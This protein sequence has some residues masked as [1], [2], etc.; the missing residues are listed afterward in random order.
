MHARAYPFRT[1]CVGRR[2][3]KSWYLSV[4]M[5]RG[6]SECIHTCI[7]IYICIHIYM[8]VCATVT[9][10][11]ATVTVACAMVVVLVCVYIYIYMYMFHIGFDWYMFHI[12]FHRLVCM[13]V[14]V[15]SGHRCTCNG[16]CCMCNGGRP[17]VYMYASYRFTY[18]LYRYSTGLI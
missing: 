5:V 16:H 10:A 11:H 7:Y 2:I 9:V 14:C 13:C 18:V 4:S 1:S 3:R 15:L 6:K 8:Y 12:G 17:C